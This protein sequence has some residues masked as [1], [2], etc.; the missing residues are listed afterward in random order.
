M[1]DSISQ[2]AARYDEVILKRHHAIRSN[3]EFS[4]SKLELVRSKL[5]LAP[6]DIRSQIETV[7]TV[8]SY[9]RSEASSESDFDRIVIVKDSLDQDAIS[10]FSDGFDQ[11]MNPILDECQLSKPNPKGIFIRPISREQIVSIAGDMKETY[12]DLSRRVLL[13]LESKS[14]L[15]ER[16][17]DTVLEE[18]LGKYAEDVVYQNNKNFVFLLNDVI[19]YFRS[20]CVNYQYTKAGTEW[21]KWPLRNIKLR[22]SRV[23]MY[24]SLVAALGA[25]SRYEKSNKLEVLRGLIGLE[26]LKRLFVAYQLSNDDGFFRVAEYYDV[27]LLYLN[28]ED[29]RAR[30][31]GLD[32]ANRYE[33]E[34]FSILKANSD[35][36]AAELWRFFQ[37]QKG[38]WNDRFFEYMII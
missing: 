14:A 11:F 4:L 19:R 35:A 27:F 10:K 31:G 20:I 3:R 7:V 38:K 1:L 36:L 2:F 22:H 5:A 23:I 28:K 30:L 16:E 8:G 37:S 34:D 29:V 6:A 33:S 17:Y 9:G 13:L 12:A 24:F 32:Y 18:V 21:G 15:N 26:P 25:L